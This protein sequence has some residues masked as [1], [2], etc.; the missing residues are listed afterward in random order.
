MACIIKK[1]NCRAFKSLIGIKYQNT[2]YNRYADGSRLMC[3]IMSTPR[4][5]ASKAVSVPVAMLNDFGLGILLLWTFQ[6]P[7]HTVLQIIFDAKL[8]WV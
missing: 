4:G 2:V 1:T 6:I 8:R 5:R 7:A 3:D